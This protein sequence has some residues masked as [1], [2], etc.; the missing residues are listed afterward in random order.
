[1]HVKIS[2]TTKLNIFLNKIDTNS[3]LFFLFKGGKIF[4]ESIFIGKKLKELR[5]QNGFTVKKL[6]GLLTALNQPISIKMIYKWEANLCVPD[7]RI[8]NALATIYN[9]GIGS[10]FDDNSNIQ[11][12]SATELKLITFMQKSK[13]FR[14][15]MYML[16][17]LKRGDIVYGD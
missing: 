7:I 10:F 16:V 12:L 8:L 6:S 11:S 1:M 3:I 15:L 4:M 13:V 14:R 17:K 5:E 2:F 9:V